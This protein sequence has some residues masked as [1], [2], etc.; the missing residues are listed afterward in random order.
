MKRSKLRELIR[1]E[2]RKQGSG[3]LYKALSVAIPDSTGIEEFAIGV[4]EVIK[5]DYGEHTYS[6]FLAVLK[7]QLS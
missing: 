1:E 3:D 5:E 2:V 6:K 7:Q 4:A